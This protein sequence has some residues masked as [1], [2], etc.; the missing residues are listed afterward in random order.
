MMQELRYSRLRVQVS[1]PAS[2]PSPHIC[3]ELVTA[4]EAAIHSLS[5]SLYPQ[6]VSEARVRCPC[7][8][9]KVTMV[10]TMKVTIIH[11]HHHFPG[12]LQSQDQELPRPQLSAPA[13]PARVPG[14]RHCLVRILQ[15]ESNWLFWLS[16]ISSLIQVDTSFI[17]RHFPGDPDW[18]ALDQVTRG[19]VHH[20]PRWLKG[21]DVRTVNCWL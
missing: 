6:L 18:C 11:C 12:V 20:E 13:V 8:A 4:L 17:R 15:G 1:A 19:A 2:P 3:Q 5:V 9:S 7:L 21:E 10:I 14:Q 16:L